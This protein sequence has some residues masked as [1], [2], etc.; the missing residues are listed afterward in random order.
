MSYRRFIRPVDRGWNTGHWVDWLREQRVAPSVL[1]AD[2]EVTCLTCRA[3]TRVGNLGTPYE[4][5]YDCKSVVSLSLDGL[6]PICYSVRS[7]LEAVLWRAKNEPSDAWLRIPLGAL[8]YAFLMR[9]ERCIEAMYGGPFDLRVAVPS[10]SS[11]RG[12]VNHL[13]RLIGCVQDFSSSWNS[14]ALVKNSASKAKT[15]RAEIIEGLFLASSIVEGKRILLLDDTFTTG[16]TLAN[17][18]HALKARGARAV[19]GVTIGRQL[20]ETWE[21]SKD[22]V[23]DLPKRQLELD[24]CVVHGGPSKDPFAALFGR[25]R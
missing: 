14:E 2:A 22:L 17:A 24:S 6:V 16:G 13:D 5:C 15:R 7:G 23:A 10:H 9:H 25:A 1:P 8:L 19:V 20:S 18:A 12:G 21:F 4:R 3:P 11:T